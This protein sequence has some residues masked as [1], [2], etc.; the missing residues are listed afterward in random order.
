MHTLVSRRMTILLALLVVLAL[1]L[2]LSGVTHLAAHAT[3][4]RAS[5]TLSKVTGPPSTTLTVEGTGFG[6]S[7]T[8]IT[9]FNTTTIVGT[10]TTS[11]LGSFSLGITIPTTAFPG[12]HR[13]QAT[14]RSSG[15]TDSHTF[16]V[17]TNWSQFG[18]DQAHSRT[19][20]YENVLSRTN[21]SRLTLDWIS[22]T[23]G[24]IG[25]SPAVV[26]GVVYIGSD[27]SNMYALDAKTGASLWISPTGS[28]I[29][30][31][32]AVVNGVVYIG[33]DD[34]NMYA[35]HLPGTQP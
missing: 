30:S 14:G 3:P 15:L 11:S 20:P 8:V 25:S 13:I 23:G 18:Y 1:S 6:S 5:I 33:S 32:P 21:V 17:N 28:A 7:E 12:R 34:G 2:T 29:G 27:D 4:A 31:S 35:F 24:V 26:N 10:T 22:P 19:N 16:L 9:T